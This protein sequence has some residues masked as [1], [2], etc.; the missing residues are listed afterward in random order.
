MVCVGRRHS[1]SVGTEAISAATTSG[2][3]V[4]RRGLRCRM[5]MCLLYGIAVGSEAT[6]PSPSPQL[7]G[8]WCLAIT[9]RR[10]PR[11]RPPFAARILSALAGRE[12]YITAL[13]HS[14]SVQCMHRTVQL[15]AVS[16]ILMRILRVCL[17]AVFPPS[18][19]SSSSSA[20]QAR[21]RDLVHRPSVAIRP[22]HNSIAAWR[23][24]A[25]HWASRRPCHLSWRSWR[26]R[27]P[28]PFKER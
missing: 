1:R 24:R 25:R 15:S 19:S 8:Q 21:E 6:F 14:P 18:S 17:A 16:T 4:Q 11:P 13:P 2:D 9:G 23:I 5:T 12:H 10:S 26:P 7:Q 27:P 28:L 3:E 20:S 22:I